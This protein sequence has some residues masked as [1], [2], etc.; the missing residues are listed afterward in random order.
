[1]GSDS[2][3][4]V[5]LVSQH[6]DEERRAEM[7]G[8]MEQEYGDK[9]SRGPLIVR[10]HAGPDPL[11][12]VSLA[13]SSIGTLLSALQMWMKLSEENRTGIGKTSDGRYLFLEPYTREQ[14]ES[15]GGRFIGNVEG[16]MNLIAL[17]VQETMDL[18]SKVAAEEE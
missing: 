3:F 9:L 4:L 17:S 10:K 8:E 15:I 13:V 12:V 11:S 7:V 18:K 6:P 5:E 1:M 16:D 2:E 14:V